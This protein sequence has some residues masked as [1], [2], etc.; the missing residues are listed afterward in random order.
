MFFFL[1]DVSSW[2]RQCF[3]PLAFASAGPWHLQTHCPALY[4]SFF[5]VLLQHT[6][7]AG[8]GWV[9]AVQVAWHASRALLQ[10]TRAHLIIHLTALQRRLRDGQVR[11]ECVGM[12]HSPAHMSLQ[13]MMSPRGSCH[14]SHLV[15]LPFSKAASQRVHLVLSLPL[16]A[17]VPT[18]STHFVFTLLAPQQAPSAA[19]Q[20]HKPINT[21]AA[22]V[23]ELIA[24]VST[25][26]KLAEVFVRTRWGREKA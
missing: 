5:L 17:V 20:P 18:V 21:S 15:C 19:P 22:A 12:A 24:A 6:T 10:Y 16:V 8:M 9:C 7:C 4:I 23:E 11:T 26:A 1:D 3:V 2:D 14:T 13:D 25:D